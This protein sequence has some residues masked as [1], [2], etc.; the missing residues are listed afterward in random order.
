[1][2]RLARLTV[3]T[4]LAAAAVA[5][6]SGSALAASPVSD[7]VRTSRDHSNS[8]NWSGYAAY[9]ATFSDAKGSWTVPASN[10]SGLK[11]N[12]VSIASPWVGFDGYLSNTVEQ[13]GTDSDCIGSTRTQYVAWYEFYPAGS[14]NLSSS[15]YPVSPG[16]NMTAE[17]AHAGSNVTVTLQNTTRNWTFSTSQSASGL[18]FSS[19]EWIMEAPTQTL[20]NFGTVSFSNAAATGGTTT[21]GAI[22]DF[23][24][25]AMTMVT[26]NGRTVRARPST[27]TSGGTAFSVNWLHG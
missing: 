22:S 16:D 3:S 20:T 11:R 18:A 15:T 25:D 9:N 27:L 5:L 6:F 12:Q 21:N 26:K 2:Q 19:A 4:A 24:N 1:M 10:C 8:T 13:T 14:V 17:V 23:T 7:L